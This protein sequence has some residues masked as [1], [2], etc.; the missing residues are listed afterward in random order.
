VA[1]L[2]PLKPLGPCE[3]HH[4]HSALIKQT[5]I[6]RVLMLQSSRCVLIV[7]RIFPEN[8]EFG[9]INSTTKLRNGKRFTHSHTSRTGRAKRA[10]ASRHTL[11]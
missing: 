11:K 7:S 4:I 9:M 10:S 1:P 3:K 2:A 5:N 6:L 8:S